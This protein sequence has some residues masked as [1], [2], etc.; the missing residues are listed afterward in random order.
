MVV[1]P[2]CMLERLKQ[3]S[4]VCP[5]IFRLS[6]RSCCLINA[7]VI[8]QQCFD[9]ITLLRCVHHVVVVQLHVYSKCTQST[10]YN[11]KVAVW[12]PLIGRGTAFCAVR[13]VGEVRC[14]LSRCVLCAACV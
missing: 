13:S 5:S 4:G 6:V 9:A 10:Y 2:V 7:F 11:E 14:L 8:Y 1:S 3:R 12:E